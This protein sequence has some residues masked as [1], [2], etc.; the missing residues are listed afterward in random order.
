MT[1]PDYK[2][3]GDDG[4]QFREC[5]ADFCENEAV[6]GAFCDECW[7]KFDEARDYED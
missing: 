5:R 3:H 2:T 7:I 4:R 1:Q 6:N